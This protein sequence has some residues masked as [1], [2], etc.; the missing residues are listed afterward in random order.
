M[1]ALRY[2]EHARQTQEQSKLNRVPH[3]LLL[4][5]FMLMNN[6]GPAHSETIY[7]KPAGEYA[8]IDTIESIQ[9]DDILLKGSPEQKQTAIDKVLADP[10]KYPPPVLYCM[11]Q[12]L[13]EQGK[14]EEA[15]FWYLCG[16]LRGRFDANRCADISA[17]SAID[18]LNQMFAPKIS[19]YIREHLLAMEPLV[20]K[21][22]SWDRTTPYNYDHRWI[23][24]HGMNSF[25]FDDKDN[26]EPLSLPKS[27]WQSIAER[28]RTEYLKQFQEVV[29]QQKQQRKP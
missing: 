11:S 10:S 19:P 25:G 14:K 23:N 21:V 16:Q 20:Q 22:V 8:K 3:Y 24:L 12:A 15:T 7:V 26:A 5:V 28:T 2:S 27:E 29:T 18:A 9:L 4:G 17:R 1:T 6:I 13:M